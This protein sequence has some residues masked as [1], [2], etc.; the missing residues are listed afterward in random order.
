MIQSQVCVLTKD[1]SV[2][3]VDT[4]KGSDFHGSPNSRLY[5]SGSPGAPLSHPCVI[6]EQFQP[7][8]VIDGEFEIPPYKLSDGWRAATFEKTAGS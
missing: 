5:G 1:A 8:P 7:A 3:T 6:R 4:G 2:E